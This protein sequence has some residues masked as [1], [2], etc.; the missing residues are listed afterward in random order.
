LP[1]VL[2][3]FEHDATETPSAKKRPLVAGVAILLSLP[4]SSLALCSQAMMSMLSN[5]DAFL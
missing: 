1:A 3:W 5:R 2:I 4:A